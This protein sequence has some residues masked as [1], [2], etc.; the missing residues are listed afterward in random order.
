MARGGRILVV[1]GYG[2]VGAGVSRRLARMF[3]DRV[4]VAGR[5]MGRATSAAAAAG[6]GTSARV[7]DVSRKPIGRDLDGVC[8]VVV[9]IDQEETHFAESCVSRGIHYIDITARHEFLLKV[10]ALDDQA[11]RA[12]ATAILSVGVAPGLTNL[13]AARAVQNMMRV[14]RLDILVEFGVGDRHGRA[15]VEW[16]LQNLDA[17]FQVQEAGGPRSVRSFGESRRLNLPGKPAKPAYRFN[18]SDQNVVVRTLGIPEVSTWVRFSS[19]ALTKLVATLASTSVGRLRSSR[20]RRLIVWMLGHAYVGTDNC[21][22]AVRALGDA[23]DDEGSMVLGVVGRGEARMTAIACAETVRQ[24][25]SS[26]PKP[27]VFHSE[28]AIDLDAVVCALQREIRDLE[29]TLPSART[30]D[31]SQ[32][33]S[34]AAVAKPRP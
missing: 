13:L 17:V 1:G 8:A 21:G 15:A 25:L 4:T 6:Y 29:V 28:Q 30:A 23:G 32:G 27:G 26:D 33:P 16:T 22:I 18:L 12:G 19:R 2:E 20:A 7:L 3:P 34:G 10:E 9:C 24:L 31:D 11:R 14:D 5:D